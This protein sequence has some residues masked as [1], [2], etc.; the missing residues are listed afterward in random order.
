MPVRFAHLSPIV[1]S[2]NWA[3]IRVPLIREN[4]TYI[5][6]V[7]DNFTRTY[8]DRT[9][10]DLIKMRMAMILASEQYVVKDGELL[11]N[12]LY[13]NHGPVDLHDIGWRASDSYFCVV[14]PKEDLEDMKGDTRRKS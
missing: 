1:H 2:T 5:V 4:G 10:P 9:L 14:L 8:S 3:L 7:G 13:V 6:Y 11:K 12:E